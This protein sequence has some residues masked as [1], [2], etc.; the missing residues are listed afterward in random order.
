MEKLVRDRIPE[1]ISATGRIPRIRQA[2]FSAQ[3]LNFQVIG[4]ATAAARTVRLIR[5]D[6]SA[7][8]L[9]GVAWRHQ[10]T[11]I[12]TLVKDAERASELNGGR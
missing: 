8:T 4:S 12:N 1:I 2:D 9:P 5:R 7:A 11:D 6:G 10:K 3:G